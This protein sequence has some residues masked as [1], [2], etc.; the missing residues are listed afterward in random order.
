MFLTHSRNKLLS[1]VAPLKSYKIKKK[2]YPYGIDKN[3]TTETLHQMFID[4]LIIS[5]PLAIIISSF[6][7]RYEIY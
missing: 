1:D 7:M 5:E 6:K 3:S 4:T 2:M